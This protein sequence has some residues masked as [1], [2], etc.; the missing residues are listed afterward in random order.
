M[1]EEVPNLAWCV[2]YTNASWT[3]RADMTAGGRQSCSSYMNSR[4]YTHAYP[5]RGRRA[6]GEK[7]SWDIQAGYVLRSPHA[8]PKSGTQRPWNVRQNFFADAIDHRFDHIDESMIFGRAGRS[9]GDHRVSWRRNPSHRTHQMAYLR[10][11]RLQFVCV[12]M[13]DHGQLIPHPFGAL[14]H[15]YASEC[16]QY[17]K[18]RRGRRL[19]PDIRRP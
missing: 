13:A 19:R 11:R 16:F 8:L 6:H 9:D 18:F 2:G 10:G 4:G 14:S 5:H 12:V 17:N 7:F 3:L 1:L 15:R